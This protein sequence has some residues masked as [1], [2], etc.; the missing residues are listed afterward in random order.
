MAQVQ[1]A[2]NS[3]YAKT[4][5][6]GKFLDIAQ[7]STIPVKIDDILFTVNKIYAYRP[8]LL[9]FDLYGESAL[10]WVFA[11]RNPN[12]IQDPIFDMRPGVR[13]FLPKKD[14]LPSI[15]R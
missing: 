9:A 12:V 14:V 3:L 4:P 13:I 11:L 5:V 2:N 8:D 7:F 6:Y 1:Y 10:W 15:V